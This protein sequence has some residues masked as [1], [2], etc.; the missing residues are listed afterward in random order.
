MVINIKDPA[1]SVK[2]IILAK[3]KK[4]SNMAFVVDTDKDF[5]HKP[6]QVTKYLYLLTIEQCF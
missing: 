4:D 5:F 3:K 6:I 1:D 2:S